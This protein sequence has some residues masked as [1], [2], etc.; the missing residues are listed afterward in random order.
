LRNKKRAGLIPD[1][2]R[3]GVEIYRDGDEGAFPVIAGILAIFHQLMELVR[4]GLQAGSIADCQTVPSGGDFHL[5]V[6]AAPVEEDALISV[7]RQRVVG[8]NVEFCLVACGG[9]N[10]A[11]FVA[12]PTGNTVRVAG[13]L[14]KFCEAFQ[15]KDAGDFGRGGGEYVCPETPAQKGYDYRD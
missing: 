6:F 12:H 1:F 8:R 14:M 4:G 2:L 13:I 10:T 9:I 5:V 7:N 11:I 3:Q 15:V